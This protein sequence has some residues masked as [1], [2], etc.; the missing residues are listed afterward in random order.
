MVYGLQQRE[1]T[2][3]LVRRLHPKLGFQK[4][5]GFCIYIKK[6]RSL[7]STFDKAEKKRERQ[8]ARSPFFQNGGNLCLAIIEDLHVH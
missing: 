2:F 5:G 7:K 8:A 4:P 1:C 3:F 6:G